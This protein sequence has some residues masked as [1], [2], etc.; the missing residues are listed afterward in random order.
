[1]IR[2]IKGYKREIENDQYVY[3]YIDS[4]GNVIP[5]T[6]QYDNGMT[7]NANIDTTNIFGFNDSTL[8][9]YQDEDI[10]EEYTSDEKINMNVIETGLRKVYSIAIG[11]NNINPSILSING[12]IDDISVD[13][14]NW[15]TLLLALNNDKSIDIL[16][17]SLLQIKKEIND[18]I[19]N[20]A[21]NVNDSVSLATEIALQENANSHDG[22][23]DPQE[24]YPEYWKEKNADFDE[25]HNLYNFNYGYGFNA[26][27]ENYNSTRILDNRGVIVFVSEG[28]IVR[29][30]KTG[31]IGETPDKYTYS[32]DEY[33]EVYPKRMYISKDGLLCTKEYF[34][35][36]AATS[37]DAL[38]TIKALE[39]KIK[40]LEERITALENK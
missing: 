13:D 21:Q 14:L 28:G 19:I 16:S 35:R 23:F 1:M 24:S 32:Y 10:T 7:L 5:L 25:K 4:N 22:L 20:T 30:H 18:Y 36:E 33:P 17:K 15:N 29:R 2:R 12:V 38:T 27:D 31:S 11:D 6:T 34:D 9:N 39:E 26:F 3:K 40:S 37:E 8:K